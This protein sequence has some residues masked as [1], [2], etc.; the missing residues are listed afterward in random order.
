VSAL[1]PVTL[2]G[3]D[4]I[5]EPLTHEHVPGLVAAADGDRS[6]FTLTMV[7]TPDVESATSYVDIALSLRGAGT[8]LP[9]ATVRRSDGMVVGS[10]RFMNIETWAWPYGRPPDPA[11]QARTTP[12]A[13]EIGATW[14]APSAQRTPINT[15]AKLLM[16]TYAFETWHLSRLFLKTDERNVRSRANI[17]R[18]GATFEGIVRNHM[19]A[20]DTG[21]RNSAVY[22]II[23]SEWPAVKDAL[24]TRMTSYP[25]SLQEP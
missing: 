9:F 21:V 7:P 10:T 20:A 1:Q 22:S 15:E 13:A 2:T 11:E 24:T 6:T 19:Y 14:L 25:R 4:V 17:E 5:L 12:H 16:L 8:A 18:I 3:N 23:D